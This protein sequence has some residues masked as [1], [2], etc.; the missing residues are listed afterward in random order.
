[1]ILQVSQISHLND[2][3]RLSVTFLFDEPEEPE[4]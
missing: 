3:T 1:M 2:T 4:C